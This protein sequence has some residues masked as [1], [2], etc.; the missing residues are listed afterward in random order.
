MGVVAHGAPVFRIGGDPGGISTRAAVMMDRANEFADIHA[1]LSSLTSD[2]W[3]G[4]AADHFRYKFNLQIKGWLDAQIAFSDASTAYQSY[5]STLLSAQSQC[6]EIRSRWEQGRNAVE[7]AQNN[8]ANA[9]SQAA[10]EGGTPMFDA[11]CDEGPGR[12][13]MAAAEADFQ[14]LVN[15]V[16]ESGTL[17]I[18]A[19][20][21]GISKLP[22][23]TWMDSV[24]R[25]FK[26]VYD[27]FVEAT[28]DLVKLVWFIGGQAILYDIGR[29]IS[30]Y[31]TPE[32]LVAKW[33]EL[34]G[35][36]VAGLF[37]VLSEKPGAFF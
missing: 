29:V 37:K 26:S 6:D 18:N 24:A 17:L 7:Q 30:G 21:S 27:G 5:A 4:R 33:V 22:E 32:E 20:N 13:T 28:I 3:Q 31:M 16:N 2:G 11:S 12:S 14:S 8:K 36:T 15:Q 10:A 23:R 35:E 34:P 9:R 25:T 1:G 19:L